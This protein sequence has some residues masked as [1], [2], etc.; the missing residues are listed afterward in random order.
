[1][2][3]AATWVRSLLLAG[4]A[5]LVLVPFLLRPVARTEAADETLVVVTPHNEAIR[6]EFGT[7]FNRWY[8]A[9][10]GRSVRIDWRVI[11]GA[12]ETVRY[13]RSGYEAAFEEQWRRT[14]HEPWSA[15]LAAALFD[16]RVAP[17]AQP[18]DDTPAQAVRRAFLAA[19]VGVGVDVFFGGGNFEHAR[20]ARAGWLVDAGLRRRHPEWFTPEVFPDVWAGE[21]LQDP[22]GR[23]YGAVLSAYGILGNRDSLSRLGLAE[24]TTWD[25]LARPELFGE[26]ALTDPTRSASVAAALEMIVQEQMERR[27]EAL[28]AVEPDAAKRETRAVREGWAQA[29]RLLQ[30]AAANARYFTDSAQKPPIDVAQG[31]AAVGLCIDFYGRFEEENLRGREGGGRVRFVTPRGGSAY[32]C[33]PIA[34]LRGAPHRA[35]A[36]DFIEFVLS[37]E[38]QRLWNQRVGTPGGPERFALRRLPARRDYYAAAELRQWRSDPE[39]NPYAADGVLDYRAARTGGMLRELA[40]VVRVMCQDPH[41][42]LRAAWRA[43]LAAGSPPELLD[44]LGEVEAVGYDRVRGE[45]RQRL[46]ARDKIDEMRLA[47]ELTEHF[48]AQYRSVAARATE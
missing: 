38:G 22:Q 47:R 48:R 29:M 2:R 46:A 23:W 36:V 15:A 43:V 37:E 8:R 5:A 39:A 16:D 7:A 28:R 42:E 21:E 27:S 6:H 30:R 10:T 11:G 12:S 19:E 40:F 33:D 26:V 34:L 41:D 17:A 25:D 35:L 44:A 24:P 1:M 13:L 9:R 31:D 18:A 3:N 45:I 14:R 4:L 32:T 20:G